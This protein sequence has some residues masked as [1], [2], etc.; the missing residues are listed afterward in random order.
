MEKILFSNE[1]LK[2]I[3]NNDQHYYFLHR[4]DQ[5][6]MFNKTPIQLKELLI[7]RESLNLLKNNDNS[8]D[9][10]FENIVDNFK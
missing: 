3:E 2:L 7:L 5:S 6:S 4:I 10:Y 9:D 8:E 1:Q